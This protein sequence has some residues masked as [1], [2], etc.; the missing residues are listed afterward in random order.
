MVPKKIILKSSTSNS[1]NASSG[2]S[3]AQSRPKRATAMQKESPARKSPKL[4]RKAPSPRR[5]RRNSL[6]PPP[7][8]DDSE[9]GLSSASEDEQKYAL[10]QAEEDLEISSV[11]ESQR[12]ASLLSEEEEEGE[13]EGGEGEEEES[14]SDSEATTSLAPSEMQPTR[15]TARQRALLQA[16]EIL[17]DSSPS[18]DTLSRLPRALT[19]EE[20]L[21]RSEKSRRRKTQRDQKLEQSKAETIQKLLQKQSSRSKKMRA[22]TPGQSTVIE[23][24][25]NFSNDPWQQKVDPLSIRMISNRNSFQVILGSDIPNISQ[26]PKHKE[27]HSAINVCIVKGCGREQKYLHSTLRKPICSLSC[28]RAVTTT[29]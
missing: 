20:Q 3:I 7:P 4:N 14:I 9:L 13:G 8:K 17:L 25:E 1:A 6:P 11:T 15:L 28:Y 26:D 29:K 21:K 2:D 24:Q 19:E 16:E 22:S 18:L 23:Q 5:S 12:S 27:T 10:E